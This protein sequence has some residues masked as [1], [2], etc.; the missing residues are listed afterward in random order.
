MIV[1]SVIALLGGSS[2]AAV[3]RI[4]NRAQASTYWSDMRVFAEA[5]GR[6]AQERGA[7]PAAGTPGQVPPGMTGYLRQSNWQKKSPIGGQYEWVD[8][9][10]AAVLGRPYNAAIRVAGCTWTMDQLRLLDRWFDD[11]NLTTGNLAVADAGTTVYFV[12]ERRSP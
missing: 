4:G 1:T 11:G 9:D 10:T 6:Y 8:K 5:Y 12:I 2:L 7:Y 3:Q